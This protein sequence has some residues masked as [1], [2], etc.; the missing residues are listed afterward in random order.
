LPHLAKVYL[1]DRYVGEMPV[2]LDYIGEGPHN[3]LVRKESH[4]DVLKRVVVKP[5]ETLHLEIYL[6]ID[7]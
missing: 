4:K 5:G 7:W 6:E 1:D 3:L 2:T